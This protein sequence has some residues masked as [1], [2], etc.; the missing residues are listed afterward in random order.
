VRDPAPAARRDPPRPGHG[1]GRPDRA[2]PIPDRPPHLG[3]GPAVRR[4]TKG[5]PVA[6][7]VKDARSLESFVGRKPQA[8]VKA[9]GK[10]KGKAPKR[11]PAPPLPPRPL[12]PDGTVL[13]AFEV[14]GKPVP[15]R[16][17]LRGRG[18]HVRTQ[19]HVKAWKELV[20]RSAENAGLGQSAGQVPY[21]GPVE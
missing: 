8:K 2:V 16:A 15:W 18:N 21:Q 19:E 7:R 4:T 11:P 6:I 20:A 13:A 12:E 5:M 17:P 10:G 3:P 1:Q 9:K 14:V